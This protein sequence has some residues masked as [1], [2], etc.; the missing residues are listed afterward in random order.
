MCFVGYSRNPILQQ[1]FYLNVSKM[2]TLGVSLMANSE[3]YND[4]F[5]NGE[6]SWPENSSMLLLTET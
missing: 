5:D 4:E 2:N 1:R 3:R 6:Q